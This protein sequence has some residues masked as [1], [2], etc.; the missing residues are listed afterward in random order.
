MIF[1]LR[2]GLSR[3]EIFDKIYRDQVW[4]SSPDGQP[5]SGP[6]TYD[7]AVSAYTK[8]VSDLV[9][10]NQIR[11]VVEIGCGDFSVTSSYVDL[12]DDYPGIDASR[13]VVDANSKKFGSEKIRFVHMDATQFNH[14][15]ADL[16]LIR[17]VLQHLDNRSIKAILRNVS[18][19]PFVLVTEHLPDPDHMTAPN[20]NK[21]SGP[22]T[23]IEFG[24]GVFVE[25]PPFSQPG[26]VLLETKLEVPQFHAGET[27]RTTLI[28]NRT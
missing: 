28:D 4:G 14:V 16:C 26:T 15:Q 5:N 11:K 13:L 9:E 6:G 1:N 10:A 19:V 20:V 3:T 18:S 25:Q 21:R 17:Q 23:R 2:F 12:I 7:P 24:S 8:L 22:D 27:L